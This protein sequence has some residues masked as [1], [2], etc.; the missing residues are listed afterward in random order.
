MSICF[1]LEL[2]RLLSLARL[3]DKRLVN[4]WNDTTTSNSS[5]DKSIQLFVTTN[6]QL[7]MPRRDTLDFEILAGVAR[8]LEDFGCQVLENGGRVNRSCGSDA[9]SLVYRVLEETVHTADGE[10]QPGFGRTRLRRLFR[11]RGFS[12]LSALASFSTFS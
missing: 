1:C 6:G 8:Q 10:L 12:T 2:E 4:V 11:R 7:Q 3:V 5:L 9:V